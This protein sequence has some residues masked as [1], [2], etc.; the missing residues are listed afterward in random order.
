M[1]RR[2]LPTNIITSLEISYRSKLNMKNEA[3]LF[4]I[5]VES[6]SWTGGKNNVD[7]NHPKR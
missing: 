6:K 3:G 2:V 4:W 5:K 1:W 7:A